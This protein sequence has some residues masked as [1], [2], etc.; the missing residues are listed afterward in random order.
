MKYPDAQNIVIGNLA[1]GSL[2]MELK[3]IDGTVRGTCF[4]SHANV[5][6]LISQLRHY[7]ALGQL[8][9]ARPKDCEGV[10]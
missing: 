4:L 9:A 7:S 2:Y 6:A 1:D 5:E 8:E 10:A 3:A